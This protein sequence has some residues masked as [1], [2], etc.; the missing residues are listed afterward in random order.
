[1]NQPSP[2]QR[3]GKSFTDPSGAASAAIV[4]PGVTLEGSIFALP[5][6]GREAVWTTLRTASEIY[7]SLAFTGDASRDGRVLATP[8]NAARRS[9]RSSRAEEQRGNP[10]AI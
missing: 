5:V 7:D 8:R 4:A 10:N 9:G 6:H 3:W 2:R 1:M